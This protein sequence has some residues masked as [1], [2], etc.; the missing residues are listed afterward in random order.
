MPCRFEDHPTVL[1]TSVHSLVA[2]ARNGWSQSPGA[3]TSP[4]GPVS[5]L[6]LSRQISEFLSDEVH[7]VFAI[8]N[9]STDDW[10]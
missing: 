7:I 1:V 10:C 3:L 9:R 2:I 6:P 5:Q 4:Y 8:C